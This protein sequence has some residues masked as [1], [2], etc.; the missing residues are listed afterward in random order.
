MAAFREFDYEELL[1]F[2][3]LLS[4]ERRYEMYSRLKKHLRP[5]SIQYWD[6]QQSKIFTGIIH[7]GRY[8]KYMQMLKKWLNLLVGKSLSEELFSCKTQQDRQLLYDG[9]WNNLRWR[10]FTR[11]FLSR[12]M[13]T[14]LFTGKFFDQLEESFSFG[15]HFRSNIKR[16]IT[17]LPLK[18]NYFLA[19][20]LMGKYYNLINLPVYLQ[21][22]NFEKIK[23]RIDR[24]EIVT[25]SCEDYFRGIPADSISKFNYSNIFEWMEPAAFEN[26]LKETIRVGTDGSILTY[27]NLLVKRSRPESLATWIKPQSELSKELHAADR[28]FIYR[29]YVVEKITKQ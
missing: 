20:V 27:R 25:G 3:G 10:V 24:I 6:D 11:V 21:K 17:T 18:E 4:S 14:L 7:C 26:L 29:A 12:A 9:K 5:E 15:D 28:S 22:E 23:N 16:A 19:Y 8:E 2:I 13:M 1:E